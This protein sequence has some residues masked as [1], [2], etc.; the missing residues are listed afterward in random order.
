MEEMHESQSRRCQKRC[1]KLLIQ[2]DDPISPVS[3]Y[4]FIRLTIS[5][6][7]A[8]FKF[9][10]KR[11]PGKQHYI[12]LRSSWDTEKCLLGWHSDSW[13][14]GHCPGMSVLFSAAAPCWVSLESQW[15]AWK[16]P[17]SEQRPAKGYH[18]VGLTIGMVSAF[19]FSSFFGL[20]LAQRE[21][22]S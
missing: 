6:S 10:R 2:Y 1:A 5:T 13:Y 9:A 16:D 22:A 12:W 3:H 14:Y 19:P 21:K 11:A 20:L 4:F 17:H 8:L 15:S 7:C 18:D